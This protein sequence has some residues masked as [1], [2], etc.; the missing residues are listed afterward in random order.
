M[1]RPREFDPIQALQEAMFVFW[2]NEYEQTTIREL[3]AAMGLGLPS[4]YATFG[5]KQ[6]LFEQAVDLYKN[7]PEYVVTTNIDRHPARE[8]IELM[9]TRAAVCYSDPSHPPGC[10]LINDPRLSVERVLAQQAILDFLSSH[11]QELPA[12]ADLGA[13]AEFYAA[14][15]RGL[16]AQAR[17]GATESRLRKVVDMAM[18][19]WPQNNHASS[20]RST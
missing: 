18:A 20:L 6:Q 2:R 3:A 11:K 7:T 17:D 15:L 19:A 13:V 16:S 14:V 4:L 10:M 12:G 8:G 1:A 9:L 5:S